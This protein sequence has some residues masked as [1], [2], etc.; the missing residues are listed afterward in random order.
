MLTHDSQVA[1]GNVVKIAEDVGEV[2]IVDTVVST[3]GQI[4]VCRENSDAEIAPH[5]LLYAGDL[6]DSEDAEHVSGPVAPGAGQ[7][8]QAA[9]DAKDA[10]I[11]KLKAQLAS[12]QNKV[13]DAPTDPTDSTDS[14]EVPEVQ[15]EADP[16]AQVVQEG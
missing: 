1:P 9:S 5:F 11:A 6:L 13:Q 14:G 10:E 16:N 8:A 7:T 12:A 15:S 3:R 2:R 4:L